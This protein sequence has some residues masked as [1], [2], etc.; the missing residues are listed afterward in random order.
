M[1]GYSDDRRIEDDSQPANDDDQGGLDYRGI[2]L[3]GWCRC[4]AAPSSI[5]DEYF[6]Y[7]E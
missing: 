6:S 7:S 5:R 3:L 2:Q 4:H 1:Q